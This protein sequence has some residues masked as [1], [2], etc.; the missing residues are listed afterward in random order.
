VTLQHNVDGSLHFLE[1]MVGISGQGHSCGVTLAQ[2]K[3][4]PGPASTWGLWL[5][6]KDTSNYHILHLSNDNMLVE[7]ILVDVSISANGRGKDIY[8]C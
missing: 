7:L 3:L 1:S 8:G 2:E 5:G 4:S 6:S